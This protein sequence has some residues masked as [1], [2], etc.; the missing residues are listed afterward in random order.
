MELNCSVNFCG[1]LCGCIKLNNEAAF[2]SD[3]AVK[4]TK[5]SSLDWVVKSCDEHTLHLTLEEKSSINSRVGSIKLSTCNKIVAF[6][7][8][9]L[10]NFIAACWYNHLIT[11]IHQCPNT[12]TFLHLSPHA[13]LFVCLLSIVR[14]LIKQQHGI[15]VWLCVV[16]LIITAIFTIRLCTTK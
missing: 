11:S 12:F 7:G 4:T 5:S 8:Y 3:I 2:I 14:W 10:R 15:W 16:C 13:H 6:D 1:T 9:L